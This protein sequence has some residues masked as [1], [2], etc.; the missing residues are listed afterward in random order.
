MVLD[1]PI[2]NILLVDDHPPNLLALEG[3]LQ[4]L[5]QN[6]VRAHSGAEASSGC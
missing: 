2:V 1:P 4:G 3:I 5:G 6:I